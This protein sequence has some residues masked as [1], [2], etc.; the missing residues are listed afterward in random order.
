MSFYRSVLAAVAAIAIASPVLA[1]DNTA[2]APATAPAAIQTADASSAQPATTSDS[3]AQQPAPAQTTADNT[4]APTINLN[5]ASA[6]DLMKV[7]GINASR[8]RAIVAYRKKHGDFKS[9]DA[10]AKVKGFNK[11]KDA[12]IKAI[13]GQ[14][15]VN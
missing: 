8:A 13:E 1:D 14:L 9:V 7:K 4:A 5:K 11:L 15:S 10:L 3:S 6:K 2:N 12:D